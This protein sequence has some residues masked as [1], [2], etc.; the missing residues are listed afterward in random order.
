MSSR[1][2]RI[3]ATH[4]GSLIRPPELVEHIKKIEAGEPHDEAAYEAD[5]SASITHVVRQ[6]AE[7]NVDIVSDGEFSKGKNWAFYV[8]DRIGGIERRPLTQGSPPSVPA[9]VLTTGAGIS[10]STGVTPFAISRTVGC[11]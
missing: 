1:P 2:E 4:V 8:H 3:L 5:L 11:L 9:T 7:A 10:S 6:Q